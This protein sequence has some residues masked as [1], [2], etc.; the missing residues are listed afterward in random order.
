[1]CIRFYK[2]TGNKVAKTYQMMQTA[3]G[4]GTINNGPAKILVLFHHSEGEQMSV[5]CDE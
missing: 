2:K 4:D 5:K 3:F 1:M